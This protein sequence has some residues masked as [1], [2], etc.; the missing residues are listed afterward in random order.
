[1]FEVTLCRDFQV[2]ELLTIEIGISS[3]TVSPDSRYV[4]IITKSGSMILLT[5]PHLETVVQMQLVTNSEESEGKEQN[6]VDV[7]TCWRQDGRYFV[8][9]VPNKETGKIKQLYTL[10][11]YL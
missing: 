6:D 11:I 9:N 4:I 10:F 5:L 1:M 7:T 2:E 3:F 8:V